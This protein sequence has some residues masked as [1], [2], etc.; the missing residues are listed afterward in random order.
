MHC[1]FE[2]GFVGLRCVFDTPTTTDNSTG[3]RHKW[4]QSVPGTQVLDEFMEHNLS[5]FDGEKYLAPQDLPSIRR[6]IH[7]D[8]WPGEGG[9]YIDRCIRWTEIMIAGLTKWQ[10]K[11]YI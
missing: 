11:G 1:A 2:E 10:W 9:G 4:K 3:I 5:V 6:R 7:V 8:P